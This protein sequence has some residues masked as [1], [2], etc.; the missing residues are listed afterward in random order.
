MFSVNWKGEAGMTGPSLADL[1]AAKAAAKEAKRVHGLSNATPQNTPGLHLDEGKPQVDGIDPDFLLA[2]GEILTYG[3]EKYAKYNWTKGI[4]FTR[5][6]ASVM[7]HLLKWY[8]CED[9]DDE[10]GLHH[11]AHAA[12]DLMFLWTY[13]NHTQYNEFDDR[14]FCEKEEDE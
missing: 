7:R 6:Y 5:I 4:H 1:R 8:A 14:P 11:L 12:C 2:I 13:A 3:A 10:S 9:E